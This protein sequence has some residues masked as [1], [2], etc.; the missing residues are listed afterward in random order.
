MRLL[1]LLLIVLN[2]KIGVS[3]DAIPRTVIYLL[4]PRNAT[5]TEETMATENGDSRT[6]IIASRT[7]TASEAKD[8]AEIMDAELLTGGGNFCGHRPAWAIREYVGNELKRSVT[9]CGLCESWGSNGN[10]S[11]LKGKRILKQLSITLP[12]PDVW[13]HAKN[14]GDLGEKD[15]GPFY[16]LTSKSAGK[17]KSR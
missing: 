9:I 4:D 13:R 12:L 11:T 6:D 7:L 3:D 15:D 14:G 1:V 16:T 17:S 10:V 5:Y 8:L 2:C